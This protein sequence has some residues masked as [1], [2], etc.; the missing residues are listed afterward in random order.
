MAKPL[1]QEKYDKWRVKYGVIEAPKK[2]TTKA[3]TTQNTSGKSSSTSSGGAKTEYVGNPATSMTKA[4]ADMRSSSASLDKN[5]KEKKYIDVGTESKKAYADT[6]EKLNSKTTITSNLSEE[7]RKTRI[8]EIKSEMS[9]ISSTM[10]G[11]S[12]AKAYGT[13]KYLE[14]AEADAKTKYSKLSDEL[15]ELE[16]VGEVTTEDMLKWKIDDAKEKVSSAQQNVTSYGQRPSIDRAEDWKNANSELYNA[17]KELE[18]LERQ[19][20][21][22]GDISKY[23]NVVNN[24]DFIGQWKSNYRSKE[25]YE[26]KA[27]AFNIYADNPTEENLEIALA[28]EGFV[29]QYMKNNENALDDEGQVL[30]LLSDNLASYLAQLK[31]SAGKAVPLGLAGAAIGLLGGKEGAKAGWTVGYS[32]GTG[33]NSYDVIRGA[34]FSELLSYGLD[35]E[36]ARELATDDAVVESLIESGETAKDWAFML[37]GGISGQSTKIASKLKPKALNKVAEVAAKYAAKP[38]AKLG[39]DITKG[40]V[41]NAGTEYL[42][43]GLQGATSRATREKAW[44]MTDKEIGQYGEGNVDLYNRPVL[45]NAD[46]SISTVDSVT[47]QIDDK[48]VLLPTIV[49]DEYGNPK[50]LTTGEEILAHYKKTGEYLGE[51][52]SL[53]EANIYANRLHNAQ[54]YRYSD[55]TSTDADDNVVWGGTKVIADAIFGG[56]AEARQELHEQGK[57]GFKT[58][59]VV[60]GIQGGIKFVV[61]S[62][63]SAKT[64]Q[65]QNEIADAVLED[66]ESLTALI[67][68]GKASGKGTVSEKIATEIETTKEN[69][70]KVSRDQVKRLIASNEVYINEEQNVTVQEPETKKTEARTAEVPEGIKTLEQAAMEVVQSREAAQKS[71]QITVDDV[72]N[73]T[74]FGDSGSVLVAKLVN[75]DG[76]SFEQATSAVD[77]AYRAGLTGLDINQ[78]NL[79][80]NVQKLAFKAGADDRVVQDRIKLAESEK[81]SVYN[82]G[83][84]EN[85]YSAQLSPDTK[86]VLSIIAEDLKMDTKMVDKIIADYVKGKPRYANASHED[87]VMRIASASDSVVFT[88]SIHEGFHRMRQLDPQ[89]TGAFMNWLY[90]DA[91]QNA[92]SMREGDSGV[93][94]YEQIKNSYDGVKGMDNTI[95]F[96]EEVAAK[97]IET[98]I[99]NPEKFLELRKKIDANPQMKSNWQKL[100]DVIKEILEDIWAAITHSKLSLEQ[101]RQAQAEIEQVEKLFMDAYRGAMKVAEARASE[102]QISSDTKE[103]TK[104]KNKFSLKE[105]DTSN[106]SAEEQKAVTALGKGAK[107]V[108]DKNGD[109][110]I[111]TNKNKSTIMYSLPTYKNGGREALEKALRANGH[112]EEEIAETLSYVDDAADYLTILAAGYAKTHNYDAL[113]NHLIADVIINVK[114]GKQVI[115]SIVNN[116]EY[117]V[118]IDLALICKKRVAYM[119]LMNRLI[120]DGIFDKVNYGGEAIAK[121]NELLRTDGFETACLGCFVESRR[122]QF[123]TWAETIVSEWNAEVDKRTKNAGSFSFAEGKAKLTDADMDALAEE[124]KNAGEKN[125]QGNLNL[126]QGSVQTR[127]GR[128][129]DKV[130]SLRKHLTVADLLTPKGITALREYDSNLFSLVKSRY[131]AASPKIVQDY[132]PYASEI[133]MMT[134][135][136]VKN[137]TSKAV[138]GADAYRQKV[139]RE[140]GGRPVK[141]KGESNDAFKDRRAEFNAKVEDEAIRR[142]LYDIGGARIQSFSDFMIENVFDYIQIFA[143][144]SAKRLPLHG[145]TKEIIA[146]RLF[147]MT[148]AKWN[149]S[150]IAHTDRDMGKEYAGLLPASDAKNGN[151]ILVH[152]DD[153]D[154]AIGFDDYARYKAT[155]KKTFIQSIGMKDMIAIQLDPRYSPYVGSITIGVSDRQILAMLDSPLFRYIIPYHASGM[156]PQFAK[157][158]GVDMYNDY[159]D[160]QN[161]TVNKWYDAYGNPCEPIRDAKDEILKVDTSYNFNAEVQ[162]TGDAKKAAANYLKWCGERHP[163]YKNKKRVGYVTFNPK[164]SDSPYGTDFTKHENYYKLLEDFNVYDSITEKSA[165]QGA[166]TMTFPSEQ[167]RLT[168]SEME[169]YKERLR[170]T[171]VF[172]EKEIE[173]YAKIAD[174]TFKELIADEVEGRA[175]Y[176]QAQTPKWENTVKEVEKMLLKDH[177]RESYSLKDGIDTTAKKKVLDA[178]EAVRRGEEGA[179]ERLKKYYE[180]GLVRTEAYNELIEKYGAIPTGEKPSREVQVPQKTAKDKKVSQTVRTVL[181]AEATPETMIPTIEKMVEDGVFSYD[182]YTD[183]QAIKDTEDYLNEYGWTASYNDF[184]RDVEKGIVSKQHTVMGWALYNNA[185]NRAATATDEAA[186]KDAMET[187]L[188]VLTAMTQ[189]QRSAA[190]ALQATRVL[191]KLSPEGQ[192]YGIQKI[193]DGYQ[194]QIDNKKIRSNKGE[195]KAD[196]LNNVAKEAKQETAKKMANAYKDG[197]VSRRG[198][199]VVIEGN[200]AG[201]P[202]VFEYAQKVGESV[203]KALENKRN[204]T[205]KEKTF[206][207]IIASQIKKFANEKLPPAEKGKTLTAVDLLRD[208]IQNQSF[209]TEAWEL[210]QQELRSKYGDDEFLGEFINSGI[211]VDANIN[212]RN[213]I[214]MRALVQS[215][216]ESQETRANIVRQSA[217]GVTKIS[218]NIAEK[219]IEKTGAKGEMAQTIRDAAAGY[220]QSVLTE[221]ETKEDN[222]L[223]AEKMVTNAIKGAMRD[224]GI[225]LSEVVTEGKIESAKQAITDKLIKKYAFGVA[226]ATHTADIIGQQFEAMSKLYANNKL[227]SMFKEREN[228]SKSITEKMQLLGR[229]G[230]FDIGSKYNSEATRRLFKSEADLKINE[231]LARKFLEA[232]TDEERLGIE[233][234]IYRDIGRQ[235]PS[236]WLDKWN[237]WRYLAMLCNLRTHG[238]NILGN[239]FFAP[240]VGV[241]N[242]TATAIESAVYHFGG[243]K[244]ERSKAMIWG[245]KNDR[246]LLKAAWEDYKNVA[247]AVS[248]GG[249][250]NDSATANKYIEEGRTIFK[251]KNP[252][253]NYI[254]KPFEWARKKNSAALEVE[255]MWF[256]Q[257]HYAYALAQYCK[258]HNI[259]PE[260]ISRGKA[261]APA[262]DYAIREASK[263]TYRDLNDFSNFVSGLGRNGGDKTTTG[264]VVGIAVEGELPFRRTPANILARGVEYSPIGFVLALAKIKKIGTETKKGHVITGAEV[265]DDISAGLT[266]SALLGLGVFMAAQGLIRGH[267][268]ED[269]D[270]KEFKELAGHQSYALE[271]PNGQSITLDWLAPEALPFFVGVNLWEKSKGRNEK[272]NMSTILA[273]LTQITA[274]M[275]EMS[276]LQGINDMIEELKWASGEETSGLMAFLSS[277]TT[278]YL[279]QGLPTIFG[280]AERTGEEY[281]MTTY[282]EKDDFLTKNMQKFLGKASAKMPFWDYRQ[283]PYID[284]WGRKEASGT[285]LKRGWNNFLNPSY[286][287]TIEE[288]DMEKE[289][290]RL[291][292]STGEGGVFPSRAETSF[293]VDKKD[294]HLTAEEYVRYATLK[295]EKSYKLVS[296]L[297]KSNAYKSLSDEEKVDAIKEAYD[298]AN[299]KAKQAISNYEPQKWVYT[300]DEFG[301]NAE[302]YIAFKTEISGIKADKKENDEKFTRYD[303]IDVV[304]DMAQTSDDMWRM[305]LTE[306][307]SKGDR[308]AYDNGIDGETYLLFLE[309]LNKADKPNDS[310]NL[311]TYTQAEAKAA[312]GN[313]KG[314]SQKEK[315]TLYQSVNTTWKKN[316]Y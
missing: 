62:F 305:Y 172:S 148:G 257:P 262:R 260:Q 58:G 125:A 109:M 132:N 176:Q 244:L 307:D 221:A 43:E 302:D 150:W 119:N 88:A 114:T 120:E 165:V 285:A 195:V 35:E 127:M 129:L 139:I 264:K 131:G 163:V 33:L 200:M 146:L 30:P 65:E 313:M 291:Y 170:E 242:L 73:A 29:N 22:Y 21:L 70:K 167:N 256:S 230:A 136:S 78:V 199:R 9:E 110:L 122:L 40:K 71:R 128:L 293:K 224:I 49:R 206:L 15:K 92:R 90:E 187:A 253:L 250:Y 160:Y 152:T 227:D 289:L 158:V 312:I 265:I 64:I 193:V 276:C 23:G 216:S 106:L 273:A 217:L 229:L 94:L 301:E 19:K 208:Y 287:S 191:K 69:G 20:T 214:F 306:Y 268:G 271:L 226:E 39:L 196:D 137:I 41:I 246:A 95:D 303:V 82:T 166:V 115:S 277:A 272:L 134:F 11:L 252:V 299:Q 1:S 102:Q 61:S 239:A 225:K 89:G 144:L 174:K 6:K 304:Q 181:E 249:K 247:D 112:T 290:L 286:V 149:G 105:D 8:K 259:T 85:E 296:E 96:I 192:L 197:K 130:P 53:E 288:S 251:S 16:R 26:D 178:A 17:R 126:G 91:E 113:A 24:D 76:L 108:T 279:T 93:S 123:Q 97:H 104:G 207:Q 177:K 295:G 116:G 283:V 31:G 52:D 142:Y 219:L 84:T 294:K 103:E 10:S 314:L 25:L 63:K 86:K 162:K 240:V 67:E 211:G 2:T 232:K 179:T 38:L 18:G 234:E 48:F 117:P 80:S 50:R 135:A 98:I 4:E 99:T 101:K 236:D 182:V 258:A 309:A 147:G 278:S 231:E 3:N 202:F 121:V 255:D 155:N 311:G 59:L 254:L 75:E 205:S 34:M 14:K 238:R 310:G 201:E 74:K 56:N 261:I 222:P 300:A 143:D 60:G 189:H 183:K 175:E 151:A 315:R 209:Y 185:A 220:V 44:A 140:M 157:L 204:T 248:N 37:Y 141:Q 169:A 138:K 263:A 267:G 107:V 68:E 7:E 266:G 83:F 194:R 42:E 171:G 198:N 13:S 154:Y 233:I 218:D 145:Y 223:D 184:M 269:K 275:L 156:L 124:L 308:L 47:F 100:L 133:A 118:N 45:K 292:K 203:A 72:K 159:T 111:A 54:A 55:N 270:E 188:T 81:A 281:R 280:Q 298:Y 186:R 153:G 212:P 46:G 51:F 210:A 297:V 282:T 36:S 237:A 5:N 77:T 28:Y 243:H 66:E 32:L 235:M 87:G 241:K 168:A 180:G 161:T 316:P 79:V 245:N 190:Q 215:A 274:P 27:K 12:R 284:A 213:A 173:K 57:E 164:F 228:K